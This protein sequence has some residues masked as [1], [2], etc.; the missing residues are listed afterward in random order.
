MYVT[1]CETKWIIHKS[2]ASYIPFFLL[3]IL[4]VQCRWSRK[5]L[6]LSPHSRWEWFGSIFITVALWQLL[7]VW[8]KIYWRTNC[9]YQ[10]TVL[11]GKWKYKRNGNHQKLSVINPSTTKI[12]SV[13]IILLAVCHTVLMMLYVVHRI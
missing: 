3:Q 13:H 6:K 11:W 8:G 12:S 7:H 4:H 10:E 9:L 5:F 1:P 2:C